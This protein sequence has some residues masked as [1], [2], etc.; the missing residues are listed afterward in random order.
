MSMFEI[1]EPLEIPV[2]ISSIC[3]VTAT[4]VEDGVEFHIELYL[5]D[6]DKDLDQDATIAEVSEILEKGF[7]SFITYLEDAVRNQ[8]TDVAH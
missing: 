1:I 2:G 6:E 5:T 4:E 8:S 3:K 7:N